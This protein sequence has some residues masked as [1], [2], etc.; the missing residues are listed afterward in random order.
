MLWV[1][2]E[3]LQYLAMQLRGY[4]PTFIMMFNFSDKEKCFFFASHFCQTLLITPGI[5]HEIVM[6]GWHVNIFGC[7]LSLYIWS[8]R[9]LLILPNKSSFGIYVKLDALLPIQLEFYL[10]IETTSSNSTSKIDK[11]LLRHV[12]NVKFDPS[13]RNLTVHMLPNFV[14]PTRRETSWLTPKRESFQK[15]AA[16]FTF[17]LTF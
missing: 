7:G 16:K 15:V 6:R 11:L 1:W 12:I 8:W 2:K 9:V 4:L 14:R 13:N 10:I 17:A 3:I 5:Y